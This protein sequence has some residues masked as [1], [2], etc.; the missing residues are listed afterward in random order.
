MDARGGGG[1]FSGQCYE[2]F[3]CRRHLVWVWFSVLRRG[4]WPEKDNVKRSTIVLSPS[5]GY[6]HSKTASAPAAAAVAF[7]L[8]CIRAQQNIDLNEFQFRFSFPIA[9]QIPTISKLCCSMD[10]FLLEHFWCHSL[11]DSPSEM[12][13]KQNQKQNQI[14]NSTEHI[15]CTSMMSCP[16]TC[17]PN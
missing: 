15:S 9:K 7:G 4:M 2:T 10:H 8:A 17:E 1:L 13:D 6:A 5:V 11:D 12:H 14:Q 3:A 16:T